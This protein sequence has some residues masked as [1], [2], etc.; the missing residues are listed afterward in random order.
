MP[1][2][3]QYIAAYIDATCPLTLFERWFFTEGQ[4]RSWI[5]RN[6]KHLVWSTVK[7]C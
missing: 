5:T 2:T 7:H 4:A 1:T 3:R 6:A